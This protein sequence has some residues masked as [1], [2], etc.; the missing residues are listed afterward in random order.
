M[1]TAKK[2][3]GNGRND[4]KQRLKVHG[5]PMCSFDK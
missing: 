3:G 1:E 2:N 4:K 5:A